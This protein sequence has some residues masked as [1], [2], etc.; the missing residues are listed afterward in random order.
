MKTP[1]RNIL[2]SFFI[3]TP[4]CV[5]VFLIAR[6]LAE[7]DHFETLM[8]A[9]RDTSNLSRIIAEQAE[10]TIS[11]ID[12]ILRVYAHEVTRNDA[13]IEAIDN[14]AKIISHTDGILFQIS[15]ADASGRLIQSNIKGATPGVNLS[16]REHFAVHR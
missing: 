10:R 12:T 13:S 3:I 11:G 5:G 1:R 14:V 7:Q 8:R 16:D 4:L 6:A 2:I 9:E 15:Y